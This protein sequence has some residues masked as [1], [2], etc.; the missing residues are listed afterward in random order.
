MSR[1]FRILLVDDQKPQLDLTEDVL[2]RGEW[3]VE[4]DRTNDP[5]EAYSMFEY[6][7]ESGQ[8]YDAVVSDYNMPNITGKELHELIRE[9]DKEVPFVIHTSESLQE[10]SL[11]PEGQCLS[12][13]ISKIGGLERKKE[14]VE[15]LRDC[16]DHY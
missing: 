11:E 5:E 16:S 6:S 15:Y 9:L 3:D 4:V 1:K 14:I 12:E 7:Q 2:K 8:L 10:I 13:Y